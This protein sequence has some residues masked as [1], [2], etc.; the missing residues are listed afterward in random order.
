MTNYNIFRPLSDVEKKDME[1]LGTTTLLDK[2]L[3]ELANTQAKFQKMMRPFDAYSA[4][5]DFDENVKSKL[6]ELSTAID[7][8]T[9]KKFDFG[10]LDKYADPER[11]EFLE[12]VEQKVNKLVHGVNSEVVIG[13]RYKFKCKQ[14]GN[15]C[16]VFVYEKD[17]E[18]FEKWLNHYFKENKSEDTKE[19]KSTKK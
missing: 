4:R 10:D 1:S 9:V 5:V 12:K 14:R 7:K 15:K 16:S 2:F 19:I 18:E 6:N 8:S 3:I 17:V 13:Y 11:F